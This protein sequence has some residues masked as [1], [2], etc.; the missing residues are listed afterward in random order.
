MEKKTRR[1]KYFFTTQKRIDCTSSLNIYIAN[2]F[3]TNNYYK[4][5]FKTKT[6]FILET[7]KKKMH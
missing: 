5:C 4:Y 6:K 7:K 2:Y 1:R 3:T